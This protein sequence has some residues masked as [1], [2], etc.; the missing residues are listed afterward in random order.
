LKDWYAHKRGTMITR[1]NESARRTS[2]F[3]VLT[4]GTASTLAIRVTKTTPHNT[5]LNNPS[6]RYN[7]S[8]VASVFDDNTDQG[9]GSFLRQ[10]CNNFEENPTW[11]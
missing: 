2:T 10:R 4:R 8:P 9:A 7:T 6:Q 1:K 11:G 3:D 5:F